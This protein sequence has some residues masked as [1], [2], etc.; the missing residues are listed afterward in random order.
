MYRAVD[1]RSA[2]RD[3]R[4]TVLRALYKLADAFQ[5][6][7]GQSANVTEWMSYFTFDTMGELAFNKS[8]G[9]LDKHE[10]SGSVK[11]LRNG[12]GILG[13]VTPAPWL[14]HVAFTF[15]P[16]SRLLWQALVNFAKGMMG[17]RLDKDS[18]KKDVSYWMIEA[19]RQRYEDLN[20][21]NLYG[22][23]FAMIIAGR[24]ESASSVW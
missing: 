11:L 3:E 19:E 9:M 22:D 7:K 14:A 6:L 23:A 20:L 5:G 1:A 17:D 21:N 18:A 12:L 8:F 24:Y 16:K 4:Q 13:S 10:W 2:V 15:L